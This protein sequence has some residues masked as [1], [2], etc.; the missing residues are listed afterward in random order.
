MLVI[1]EAGNSFRIARMYYGEKLPCTT[2]QRVISTTIEAEWIQL[3]RH[4]VF[5]KYFDV[6][7]SVRSTLFVPKSQSVHDFMQDRCIGQAAMAN[8][9]NLRTF[10]IVVASNQREATTNR[11][12]SYCHQCSDTVNLLKCLCI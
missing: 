7:V 2:R 10:G 8:A 12:D 5:P 9:D 11:N 6:L 1:L 4:D 3:T